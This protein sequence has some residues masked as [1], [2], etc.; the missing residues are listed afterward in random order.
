[1]I[2]NIIKNNPLYILAVLIFCCFITGILSLWQWHD[3]WLFAH[4]TNPVMQKAIHKDETAVL[5]EDLP[6]QNLFGKA[7]GDAPITNLQF[8]VTGIVKA[9]G[10]DT[11]K[12]YISTGGKTSKIYYI[13]DKL[14]YG[15]SIYDITADAVLLENNGRI[16]KLLLARE[17]LQFKKKMAAK[18]EENEYA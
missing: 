13:G 17:P 12:A 11:S 1:M 2:I 4:Q 5:I 15:I 14:P 7:L 10:I 16:E 6:K 9:E 3:D 18:N 8:H